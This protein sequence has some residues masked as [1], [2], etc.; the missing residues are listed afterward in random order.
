MRR[1]L[2]CICWLCCLLLLGLP[3]T[4]QD[5]PPY[6][7]YYSGTLNGIV[8]ERADGTDS[9]ILGQGLMPEAANFVDGPGWSPDGRWFAWRGYVPLEFGGSAP[10]GSYVVNINVDLPFEPP[11]NTTSAGAYLGWKWHEDAE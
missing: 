6:I 11:Q 1:I 10:R 8:V 9:R 5:D 4:A 3:A 7:Y 2:Y